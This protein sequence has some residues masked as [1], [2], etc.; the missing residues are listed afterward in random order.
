MTRDELDQ[1]YMSAGAAHESYRQ[2]I[3]RLTDD[4]ADSDVL[5]SILTTMGQLESVMMGI[6]AELV[7]SRH[8]TA[9]V[10]TVDVT[11]RRSAKKKTATLRSR[12]RR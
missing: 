3:N 11:P 2:W 1:K 7:Y 9:V 5:R 6:Y 4:A 12:K 10:A 8:T